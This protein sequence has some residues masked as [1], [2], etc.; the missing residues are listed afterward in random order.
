MNYSLN[1]IINTKINTWEDDFLTWL[2]SR[3]EGFGGSI[4]ELTE[5][6]LYN[7]EPT[8]E[9]LDYV[10]KILDELDNKGNIDDRI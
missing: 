7:D 2:E 10:N 8:K 1:G 5:K 6:D 9:E 4:V 3:N